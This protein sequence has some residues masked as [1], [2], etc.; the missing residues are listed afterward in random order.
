M[1]TKSLLVLNTNR[2][3]VIYVDVTSS[4]LCAQQ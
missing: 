3:F 4:Y 2:L 1:R